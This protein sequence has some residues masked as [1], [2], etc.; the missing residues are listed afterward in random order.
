MTRII[1]PPTVG[2]GTHQTEYRPVHIVQASEH[3]DRYGNL[4]QT[5][6]YCDGRVFKKT[7]DAPWRKMEEPEEIVKEREAEKEKR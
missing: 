6:L 1:H 4:L 5:I 3:C 7:N 2:P